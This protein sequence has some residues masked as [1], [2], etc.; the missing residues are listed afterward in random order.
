MMRLT[1]TQADELGRYDSLGN[2]D[3]WDQR[4]H[5]YGRSSDESQRVWDWFGNQAGKRGDF[6]RDR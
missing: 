2:R 5:G 4:T 3:E 6:N 1:T